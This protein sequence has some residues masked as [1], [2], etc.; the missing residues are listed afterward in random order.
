MFADFQGGRRQG[1]GER[2]A[3]LASFFSLLPVPDREL[4]DSRDCVISLF[5]KPNVSVPNGKELT[6]VER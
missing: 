3:V 4:Q 1:V 5:L 6:F 2:A